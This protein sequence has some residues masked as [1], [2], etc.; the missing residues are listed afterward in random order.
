METK[1]TPGKNIGG[2]FYIP[3]PHCAQTIKIEKI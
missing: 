1:L 3:C 2:D